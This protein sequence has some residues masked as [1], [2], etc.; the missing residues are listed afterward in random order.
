MSYIIF[1][2]VGFRWDLD[3][4]LLWT[5]LNPGCQGTW[6]VNKN[7]LEFILHWS[8]MGRIIASLWMCSSEAIARLPV[9]TFRIWFW[10]VWSFCQ[11]LSEI[12]GL[13]IGAAY[14]KTLRT[15]TLYVMDRISWSWPHVVPAKD[16]M[17]FN[18]VFAESNVAL[19]WWL[20]LYMVSN[21]TLS[22]LGFNSSFTTSFFITTLGYLKI[23]TVVCGR[24]WYIPHGLAHLTGIKKWR[25]GV[26]YNVL[27]S[28]I[29]L[30]L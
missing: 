21:V 30:S 9:I 28:K 13:Q 5:C 4:K 15:M 1:W 6:L 16:F 23:V 10:T 26:L 19:N 11:L 12:M 24:S 25:K 7:C 17:M 20:K 27:L 2:M 8:L 14:S 29:K 18:L 22:S 3:C